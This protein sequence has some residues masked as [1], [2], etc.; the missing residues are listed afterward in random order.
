[1]KILKVIRHTTF[2]EKI[3][4]PIYEKTIE[5]ILYFFSDRGLFTDLK[6]KLYIKWK[7]SLHI[8]DSN[9]IS[10]LK[11]LYKGK[12]CFV[13][14]TGP[15]LKINDLNCLKDEYTFG[16]NNIY[17]LYGQMVYRPTF[18]VTGVPRYIKWI[19]N[20]N[21]GGDLAGQY[22]FLNNYDGKQKN[23]G[24]CCFIPM[25]SY[26]YANH[27]FIDH[28]KCKYDQMIYEEDINKG[29]IAKATV[30]I[31][32]I[33]IAVYLG[34]NEIVLL[35]IDMDYSKAKK[36]IYE[37]DEGITDDEGARWVKDNTGIDDSKV[38]I[39][40]SSLVVKAMLEGFKFWKYE[41]EKRNVKIINATR[42]GRL[43]FFERKS[44]GEIL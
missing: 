16:L 8:K 22:V 17:A 32:A 25:F 38:S 18:Y 21:K 5:P 41:A 12:R 43:E 24:K 37:N 6:R 9:N 31:T 35:G 36:H 30:A 27:R 34:F 39:D 20:E 10:A 29:I 14:G 1:M 19:L 2:G 13:I 23:Q 40:N 15:S 7:A 28:E 3:L 33:E 11:N 44:L 42:G 4:L 26:Y